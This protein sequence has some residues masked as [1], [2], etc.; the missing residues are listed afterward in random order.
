MQALALERRT[1]AVSIYGT[2]KRFFEDLVEYAK[3]TKHEGHLL[4]EK[5]IVRR[6]LTDLAIELEMLK[7][8][9]FHMTWKMSQ[10]EI[11]AY[12]ASRNKIMR[13]RVVQ[14]AANA[15]AEI[16]GAYSQVDPDSKW[17]RLNGIVQ[18]AYLG[19]LG[20][21]IAAGTT[22]IEKSIIAQFGLGLPKS[23]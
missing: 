7:L 3:S 9:A 5:P 1:P 18:G 4:S 19:F 21:Q 10:G 14:L 6:M 11:S 12:V 23:M 8:F 16:L 2:F 20:A 13:D 17:S 22:E 15:G